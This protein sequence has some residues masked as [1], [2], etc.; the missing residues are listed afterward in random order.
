MSKV[1][2]TIKWSLVSIAGLVLIVVLFGV[3]FI[4]LIPEPSISI[5]ELETTKVEDLLYLTENKVP[6]R[7]KVLAVVTSSD[8]MGASGKSTGYELTEL[9]RAYYVFQANGF[10]VEIASPKG[11]KP[12][13]VIDKGDMKQYSY[14]FLNDPSAQAKVKNSISMKD[15]DPDHYQALYFVGG[16]GAMFDFPDNPYIQSMVSDYYESGKVIGAVCHGPAALT[17]A[18]L[19][20]GQPLVAGKHV[21][22]FTNSEELL[23]IS[24]AREIFPFLLQDKLVEQGAEFQEG[25]MYLNQVSKDG[26]LITGQNPW[27]TWEVAESVVEQLGYSPKPR[28]ITPEE[29]SVQILEIYESQGYEKAKVMVND[30]LMAD[31][32]SVDMEMLAVHSLL[33]AYRL[34]ITKAVNLIRLLRYGKVI[35]ST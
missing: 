32:K 34:K 16:K 23:L 5:E 21:S 1:K 22:S 33:A 28:V 12:P 35:I 14:A 8:T 17:N 10:E 25:T 27:S 24:D 6:N 29:N 11:G 4:N 13:V 20:N 19:S 3:W 18:T 2:N 15:V 9:A 26:N 7:G 30:W 31:S